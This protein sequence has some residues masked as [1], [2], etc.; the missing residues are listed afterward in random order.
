MDKTYQHGMGACHSYSDEECSSH[1]NKHEFK[2]H[3]VSAAWIKKHTNSGLKTATPSRAGAFHGRM[4]AGQDRMDQRRNDPSRKGKGRHD[5]KMY[6]KYM[7]ASERAW[8]HEGKSP[9]SHARQKAFDK[10]FKSAPR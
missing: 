7:E 8:R 5:R 9:Y 10:A 3:G 6:G 2:G 4:A 1:E